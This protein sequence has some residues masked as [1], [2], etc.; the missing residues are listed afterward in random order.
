V[1]FSP[2]LL[3]R[4]LAPLL[5]SAR[6]ARLAV[7][8]SGGADSAALLHALAA[9]ARRDPGL[10]LRALHVDHGL[11]PAATELARAAGAAARL[12]GVGLG[13]LAVTVADDAGEGLEA[14]ARR[15][16]Y[17]ALGAALAP[18]ECLL[19]AHHLED[20]AETVLLQLLRGTGIRGLAAMPAAA[21]LGRGRLLRPLLAVPR[22]ALR[23]Y[24]AAVPLPA[25]EDPM[26]ADP[27]FERAFLRAR[28]WPAIAGRWPAAAG[29]LARTAAHAAAAQQLLDAGSLAALAPLRRGPAL[30]VAGLLALGAAARAEALRCWLREQGLPAP[31]TRRLALIER[32]LLRARGTGQPCMRWRGLELRTFAGFLYAFAPLARPELDGRPLP[33]AGQAIELGALGRVELATGGPGALRLA[34]AERLRLAH[35]D[36]GERIRLAPGARR[37]ALKD[38][39]REAHLPPWTRERAVLVVGEA[40]AAVV[41]PHAT[42][43]AAEYAAAAGQPALAL[44]WRDAPAVLMPAPA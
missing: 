1:D 42:W 38:L 33:G 14:A 35:R 44:A 9:L 43:V 6:P 34:G 15:A 39:L 29:A 32:E 37:R 13:V 21:P 40:L 19:T 23:A 26:N 30:A 28:L 10:V 2:A 12:A 3:A 41:L 27:R 31:S 18:G 17:A 7:A 22:A 8:L 16:R 4:H 20:Q 5:G 36:G 25:V 24:A 11:T